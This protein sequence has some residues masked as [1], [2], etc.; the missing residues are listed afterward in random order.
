[1]TKFFFISSKLFIVFLFFNCSSPKHIVQTLD[2]NQNTIDSIRY[3]AMINFSKNYKTLNKFFR[4]FKN[5]KLVFFRVY[6]DNV[7]NEYYTLS[8]S[9]QINRIPLRKVDSI[10]KVPKTFFPN[11]YLIIDDKVF[12]WRDDVKPLNVEILNLLEDYGLLNSI[13][14]N[15]ESEIILNEEYD[16]KNLIIVDDKL[17]GFHY[18]FC[19]NNIN[20]YRKVK[21]NI[22]VG[23]YAPPKINCN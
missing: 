17:K 13:N 20:K 7:Y 23:Y 19:K 3:Q 4:K 8:I 18:Y 6:E 21:T 9:H 5:E 10:G 22:A 16:E 14:S 11:N 1:M 15:Y 2:S 12:L